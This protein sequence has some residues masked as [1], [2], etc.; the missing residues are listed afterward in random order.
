V[1]AALFVE[2]NGVYFGLPDV[3]PW[4]ER[5]DAT[6]VPFR[7]LLLSMVG[8]LVGNGVGA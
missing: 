3:D 7:D 2:T 5:R 6:P 1:I 8:R 4:D